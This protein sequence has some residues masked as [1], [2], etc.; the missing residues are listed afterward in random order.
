MG[1]RPVLLLSR[2]QAYRILSRVT[3]AEVT[4]RIRA[5]AVEVLLGSDEGLPEK[6]VANLD[7]IHAV[8][9]RRLKSKAGHLSKH[10]VCEVER[11]LGFAWN[12]ARLKDD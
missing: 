2:D 9:T 11:A 4:T 8:A 1:C 5:I 3:V 7:N 10:R 12:I 6:C